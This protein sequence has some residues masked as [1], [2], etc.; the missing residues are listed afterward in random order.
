MNITRDQFIRIF[1]SN[2]VSEAL[3]A[4]VHRETEN[5]RKQAALS[6]AK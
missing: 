4:L 2:K 5:S 1:R 6:E 3:F